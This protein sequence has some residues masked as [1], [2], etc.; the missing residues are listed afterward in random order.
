[1][2]V[3]HIDLGGWLTEILRALLG[4]INSKPILDQP[5]ADRPNLVTAVEIPLPFFDGLPLVSPAAQVCSWS[6]PSE[7]NPQDGTFLF[8]VR[9][10]C[11][12]TLRDYSNLK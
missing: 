11:L 7:P 9:K 8:G 12:R 5:P 6:F 1:V 4:A 10:P 3:Q 2:E